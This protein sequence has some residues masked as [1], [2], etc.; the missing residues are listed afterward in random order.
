MIK[1]SP[2]SKKN[3]L[4]THLRSFFFD[5]SSYLP[6]FRVNYHIFYLLNFLN[7]THFECRIEC[8]PFVW[9]SAEQSFPCFMSHVFHSFLFS[10]FYQNAQCNWFFYLIFF[11]YLLNYYLYFSHSNKVYF[12]KSADLCWSTKRSWLGCFFS[13]PS[14]DDEPTTKA[15]FPRDQ[16]S[17]HHFLKFT[18]WS[19]RQ[20][21]DHKISGD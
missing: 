12:Y 20:E 16:E 10:L 1:F 11:K 6:H 4:I 18:S 14:V 13:L 21:L 2:N 15:K 8:T 19:S 17:V 5:S 3:S 9:L 7:E